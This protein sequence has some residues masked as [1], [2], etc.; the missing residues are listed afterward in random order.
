MEKPPWEIRALVA[1]LKIEVSKL[2]AFVLEHHYRE[3]NRLADRLA[4]LGSDV[5]FEELDIS[6]LS[7]ECKR[8]I[9]EDAIEKLYERV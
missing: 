4:A 7:N 3:T 2:D 1:K 8:I 9:N 5:N 6:S